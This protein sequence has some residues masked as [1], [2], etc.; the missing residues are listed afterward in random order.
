M[1]TQSQLIT[2]PLFQKHTICIQISSS[3]SLLLL[4]RF[5]LIILYH[6]LRPTTSISFMCKSFISQSLGYWHQRADERHS[7]RP[8]R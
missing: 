2:D 6:L 8:P 1:P 3:L 5:P 7:N 4:L